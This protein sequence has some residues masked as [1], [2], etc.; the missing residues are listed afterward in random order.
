M[1][2]G[3]AVFNEICINCH[4]PKADSKGLLAEAV[5]EMTGGD[6]RVANF[7]D[8]LIGPA[9]HPAANW[10]RVFGDPMKVGTAT[11]PTAE[12]WAGRYLAWMA[13]GGTQRLIPQPILDIVSST[14]VLGRQRVAF[15]G[16]SSAS[17]NMLQTA[18]LLCRLT[19]PFSGDQPIALD[20]FFPGGGGIDWT[21]LH[22][23]ITENGDADLWAN[24][25]NISNPAVRVVQVDPRGSPAI[26]PADSFYWVTK[27]D[28]PNEKSY[29]DDADVMN[30]FGQLEKGIKP[31]NIL[32]MCLTPPSPRC[33][34]AS[35]PCAA[36]N[37]EEAAK[38]TN[39]IAYR[40][41]SRMPYCP[42]QLFA[43]GKDK[44]PK[45]KFKTTGT[46]ST[47]GSVVY[48]DI[49]VW[50]TRGAINAGLSVYLYLQD[51][52]GGKI[53]PKPGYDE[54]EKLTPAASA[55]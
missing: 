13:L 35:D 10:H 12:D 32:P 54:C 24:L 33:A 18:R 30:Q 2:P 20:N 9:D 7:K 51:M 46:I 55:R 34:T 45:W 5:S 47:T 40:T 15:L 48:N 16:S 44:N 26:S 29:P 42:A 49:N 36:C 23:L 14:P 17:P 28:Y 52:L 3:E 21:Y 37:G 4:G 43:L 27:D 6:S 1:T 22:G 53:V 25:C 39:T 19:L 31:G 38:C 11:S 50:V 41:T 8:G